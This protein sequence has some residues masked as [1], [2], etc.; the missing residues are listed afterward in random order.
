MEQEREDRHGYSEDLDHLETERAD[1]ECQLKAQRKKLLEERE[2]KASL[3]ED[4]EKLSGSERH[5]ERVTAQAVRQKV[6]ISMLEK[7]L[8]TLSETRYSSGT[9]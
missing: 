7:Q 9:F 4:L 6:T 2:F 1:L 8:M 3:S 5:K